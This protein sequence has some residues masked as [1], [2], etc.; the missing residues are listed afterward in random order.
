[1]NSFAVPNA[2]GVV[3]EPCDSGCWKDMLDFGYIEIVADGDGVRLTEKGM[4]E[5]SHVTLHDVRKLLFAVREYLAIKDMTPLDLACKLQSGDWQWQF[6]PVKIEDRQ[7]LTYVIDASPL[8]FYTLGH[9]LLK[10]FVL[11]LLGAADSQT[12]FGTESVPHYCVKATKDYNLILEGKPI[13]PQVTRGRQR[14]LGIAD[15][16]LE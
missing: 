16:Q 6:M 12:K 13:T 10:D 1:M 8:Q 7:R 3:N 9:T 15:E 14:P 4:T 11:C 2:I 5:Y